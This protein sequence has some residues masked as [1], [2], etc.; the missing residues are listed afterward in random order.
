MS[1]TYA[2]RIIDQK[3]SG[4][5]NG[6]YAVVVIRFDADH[7]TGYITSSVSGIDNPARALQIAKDYQASYGVQS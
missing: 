6:V 5:I 1:A 3:I 2:V 7:P 4:L